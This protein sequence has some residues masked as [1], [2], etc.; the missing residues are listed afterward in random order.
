MA[1][2]IFFSGSIPDMGLLSDKR[3]MSLLEPNVEDLVAED[4]RYRKIYRLFNWMELTKSLRN[5]YSK[6][7]RK[8][9]RD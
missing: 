3:Q 5:L 6:Q 7:G 2:S 9:K 8:G 1:L 4:H